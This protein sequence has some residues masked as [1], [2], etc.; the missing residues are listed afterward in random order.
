MKL[1]LLSLLTVCF[2]LSFLSCKDDDSDDSEFPETDRGDVVVDS[3]LFIL[4]DIKTNQKDTFGYGNMSTTGATY[5]TIFWRT[6]LNQIRNYEAEIRY[7]DNGVDV[8][9]KIKNQ[10]TSYINCYREFETKDIELRNRGR[11]SNSDILGIETEWFVKNNSPTNGLGVIKISLNYQSLDKT[12]LC[13]SGVRIFEA[14]P[15]YKVLK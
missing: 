11:D 6:N 10:G 13:D 14:T 3:Y 4:E 7:F 15:P 1:R 12:N 8:T 2:V 9:Q 5:D